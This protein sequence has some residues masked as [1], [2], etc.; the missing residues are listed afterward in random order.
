M[1]IPHSPPS[2]LRRAV[3]SLSNPFVSTKEGS[4]NIGRK[5]IGFCSVYQLTNSP[6]VWSGGSG[7][8]FSPERTEALLSS[9]STLSRLKKA[10][11]D[12]PFLHALLPF[13][14]SQA[15]SVFVAIPIKELIKGTT[16]W[17]PLNESLTEADIINSFEELDHRFLL[18]FKWLEAISLEIDGKLVVSIKK[19]AKQF[20]SSPENTKSFR[21]IKWSSEHSSIRQRYVIWNSTEHPPKELLEAT[22][23][24]EKDRQ[25]LEHCTVSVIAG[26]NASG[27]LERIKQP[28]KLFVYY[29]TEEKLPLGVIAHGDFILN[30]SRK[31]LVDHSKGTLNF[32]LLDR[33]TALLI[34]TANSL[35]ETDRHT[36]AFDLLKLPSAQ[37]V[38]EVDALLPTFRA[39]VLKELLLPKT[40]DHKGIKGFARFEE[41]IFPD[42][43]LLDRSLALPLLQ[44]AFPHKLV[45]LSKFCVTE[46]KS[47]VA[48]YSGEWVNQEA[49]RKR[50]VFEPEF[51]ESF[52]R[53]EWCK[54]AWLWLAVT[55]EASPDLIFTHL[56]NL[57]IVPS[58][59]GLHAL[60][61]DRGLPCLVL[62]ELS[63]SE[64][65]K[66]IKIDALLKDFAL[67]LQ[68]ADAKI[69]RIV[70]TLGIQNFSEASVVQAFVNA[71]QEESKLPSD[72]GSLRY[73]DFAK[74]RKW[75][76]HPELDDFE[77]DLV[78][79]GNIPVPVFPNDMTQTNKPGQKLAILI[80]GLAGEMMIYS[81]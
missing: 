75:P 12:L 37:F 40:D 64:L 45:A 35:I 43:N 42:P 50:L 55:F 81:K 60:K 38:K 10:N 23:P 20:R 74:K 53:I 70:N 44:N 59:S 17:L 13:G 11:R 21:L 80:S 25:R 69:G 6:M 8:G 18:T 5:G 39:R 65:P 41:F 57:K 66:W 27:I 54:A 47:F 77:W 22:V 48:S 19:S 46:L 14:V 78:S 62:D 31:H 3:E 2:K 7:I 73:I 36:E 52:E 34:R 79:L 9:D 28:P 15:P 58:S 29:P 68:K 71:I 67:W 63:V 1:G 76:E 51:Q 32:W 56:R 33:L 4:D 24:S 72:S 16:V 49:L 30:G 61:D 26:V